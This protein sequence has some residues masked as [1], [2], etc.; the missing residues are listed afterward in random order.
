[1]SNEKDMHI[2]TLADPKKTT[3]SVGETITNASRSGTL[4]NGVSAINV[5]YA[6][7]SQTVYIEII[8]SSSVGNFTEATTCNLNLG[9]NNDNVVSDSYYIYN[10]GTSVNN[11]VWSLNVNGV[12][13]RGNKTTW[14]FSK[15]KVVEG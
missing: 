15:T 4:P 3:K 9:L 6:N 10:I 13:G 2:I 14:T 1:M 5:T 11:S 12:D 7:V 8:S